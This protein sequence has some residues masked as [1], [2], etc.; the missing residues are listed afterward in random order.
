MNPARSF[1]PAL[2]NGDWSHHW[3]NNWNLFINYILFDFFIQI[4]WV[5][6]LG[7]GFVGAAF[8]KFL[9]GKEEEEEDQSNTPEAIALNDKA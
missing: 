3:V 7:A 1:A 5:G 4:Y 2:L 9:F 8:Y 6:P